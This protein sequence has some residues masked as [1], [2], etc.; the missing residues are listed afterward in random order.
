M[1]HFVGVGGRHTSP[2][3]HA[4]RLSGQLHVRNANWQPPAYI[5]FGEDAID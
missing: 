2:S 4:A 3:M 5:Y 1:V